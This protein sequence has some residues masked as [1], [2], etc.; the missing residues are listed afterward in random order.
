MRGRIL[1]TCKLQRTLRSTPWSDE[2]SSLVVPLEAV[3]AMASELAVTLNT[4]RRGR[5]AAVAFELLGPSSPPLPLPSSSSEEE[6][7]ACESSL[8]LCVSAPAAVLCIAASGSKWPRPRPRP[9]TSSFVIFS[10]LAASME[11]WTARP[12]LRA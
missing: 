10:S 7:E 5:A 1:E 8:L 12:V 3:C 2:I 6:E 4:R 11:W 9:G